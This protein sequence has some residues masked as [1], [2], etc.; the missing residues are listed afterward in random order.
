MTMLLEHTGTSFVFPP[1][2]GPPINLQPLCT[3]VVWQSPDMPNGIIIGYELEFGTFPVVEV[4]A[5]A[6]FYIVPENR[7]SSTTRVR[8]S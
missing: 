4:P 3:V 8:V 5:D 7:R 2:P 6:T 1:G